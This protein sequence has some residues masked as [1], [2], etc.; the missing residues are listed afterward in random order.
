MKT[1]RTLLAATLAAGLLL[2]A[3]GD[4]DDTTDTAADEVTTTT[5]ADA[6]TT[7]EAETTTTTEAED[8]AAPGTVEV[9]AVDYAFEGL[10]ETVPAGTKLTFTNTS[11]TELHEL[12]VMRIPDEEERPLEELLALPE[13]ELGAI[14]GAGMPATVLLAPPGGEQVSAVGDGTIAE[15]G[16]YAVVCFIPTGADPA[17]YLESAGP[18]GPPDVPGGPPHIVHGMHAELVVQ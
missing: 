9:T 2:A 3:C 17:A 18:D 4:D 11:E 14:F 16:R 5:E 7:T 15:P 1:P 13:E 8:D 12:V 10:P 6:T